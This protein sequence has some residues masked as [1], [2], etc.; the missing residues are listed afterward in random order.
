MGGRL[1]KNLVAAVLPPVSSTA[2]DPLSSSRSSTARPW[3]GLGPEVGFAR[4]QSTSTTSCQSKLS[5]QSP[6]TS[7]AFD[8]ISKTLPFAMQDVNCPSV[9]G[10]RGTPDL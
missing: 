6:S 7:G 8:Q 10:V 5:V 3:R 4:T 1:M 9:L 2:D